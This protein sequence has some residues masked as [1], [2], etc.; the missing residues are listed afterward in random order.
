MRKAFVG[1]YT[2]KSRMK[3]SIWLTMRDPLPTNCLSVFDHF[4]GLV[5]K[6][7][8]T[9]L[10]PISKSYQFLSVFKLGLKTRT[11]P[12]WVYGYWEQTDHGGIKSFQ[13][14]YIN[15]EPI[16][17]DGMDKVFIFRNFYF[18]HSHKLHP[19]EIL[20]EN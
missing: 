4:V 15:M 2:L 18:F 7:L 5:L 17:M 9:L 12:F 16:K 14:L 1:R 10:V 20:T 13:L 8:K 19:F 6:E 3:L 11:S